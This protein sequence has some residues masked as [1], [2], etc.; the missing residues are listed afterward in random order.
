MG[1]SPAS[2]PGADEPAIVG[3]P[4][5]MRRLDEAQYRRAI[6]DIFGPGITIPGRF[7]PP[8]REDGLLAIGDGKVTVS[9]SGFEQFELRAREISAQVMSPA[10]RRQLVDCTPSSQAFD[11]NCAAAFLRKYGLRLY[12]RPLTD[13]EMSSLMTLTAATASQTGDFYKGLEAGLSHMLASPFF[14][15]RVERSVPDASRPGHERLDDY[16]LASRIS[17]LLWDAPPD[18]QLLEAAAAGTLHQPSVLQAQVDRLI[19]SPR[20]EDGVRAFFVDMLGY[21]RFDGLSK[22][23]S[24]YPKYTPQLAKDAEEQALRTIVD[25][26]VVQ[27]SDYRDL[28]T[29]KKTFMNRRLASVY[30]APVDGDIVQGWAPYTFGPNDPR[31]GLLSLVGFLML[32]PTHEG[33]SSPTI[34]GKTVREL[35]LCEPVPPP[36]PNVNFS[37]VQDT[38]NPQYKTARQR[39]E[40]H[41]DDPSCSGCH[42]VMDPIGLSMENYDAI[43]GYRTHENGAVI[44]ASG[45]FE[46]KH[47][48]D[49]IGLEKIMH[50]SPTVPACVVQRA[51]EYGVGRAASGGDNKWL[52]YAEAK[53]AA[54]NYVFPSLMRL[55]ATSDALQSV[56][57]PA[58]KQQVASLR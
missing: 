18:D 27:R 2:A 4:T 12:R 47:Y 37:I 49:V 5:T 34:R 48:L 8:R 44:D 33:R 10:R 17:F 15:F 38:S 23:Q 41:R 54:Q 32:D 26:L 57:A 3:G 21:E 52:S 58:S 45:A 55:I 40:A 50:D 22:D 42:A 35:L 16:S 1:A 24:I 39:L 9:P 46:G 30:R 11:R 13:Q 7:D 20:F 51:Y 19:A 28:F 53:F 29:T 6:E 36:P 14:I 43:G 31:A 25:L 56:A